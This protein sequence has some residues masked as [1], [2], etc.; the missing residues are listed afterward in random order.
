MG[1]KNRP[2]SAEYSSSMKKIFVFL[3]LFSVFLLHPIFLIG[4]VE[5]SGLDLSP[6]N[7]LLFKATVDV[8]G[9][10]SYDTLFLSTLDNKKII[11]LTYFP[12]K[13]YFLVI[14]KKLQIQN[15]F[16]VFRTDENLKN[17]TPISLFPAFVNGQEVKT[18]KISPIEAS[19]DGR[20]LTY[21][22]AKS[23]AFGQLILY[24]IQTGKETVI[25]E[26]FELDLDGPITLWSPDSKYLVYSSRGN[27]Y[28]YSIDQYLENRVLAED[29]RKFNKGNLSGCRWNK[30][31]NLFYIAGSVVFSFS[32]TD[33]FPQSLYSEFLRM[34][35]ITGSIPFDFDSNFDS[36][37]ISPDGEKI[38]LNKGGA[39]IFLHFFN[40]EDFDSPGNIQSLP[41]LYLPRNTSVKKVLW[42]FGD[43]VTILTT[44]IEK[45]DFKNT[46]FRL[47]IPLEGDVPAFERKSIE[48]VQDIAISPDETKLALL[49]E[50]RVLIYNYF[51][52][53]K[54]TEFSYNQPIKALWRSNTELLVTGIYTYHL[55]NIT[56]NTSK[57]IALSQPGDYGFSKEDK[58]ILT[59]IGSEV[60]KTSPDSVSWQKAYTFETTEKSVASN[61]YRVYLEVTTR[62]SYQNMVMVRDIRGYGTE[63]LFLPEEFEYESFPEVDEPVDFS[64]FSHGSRLR[65]REIALVFNAVDSIEGLTTILNVLSEYNLRCTF[66]INGEV[67]RRYPLATMEIAESGHEVGS[68]FYIPFNMTDAMY[69]LDKEYIKNGLGRTEDEYYNATGKEVSLLWHAPYY[70]INS[71]MIEA[72]REMN[73]IY[74]GRDVDS[75]DWVTKDTLILTSGIYLS[76]SD[77]VERIINLKK[78]G[79]IIPIQIGI[80]EEKREDYLFQKLDVLINGLLKRGYRIVTV[81]ELIENAK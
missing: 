19:P 29:Y 12:E 26:N 50:D 61:Y 73:Y 37:W 58:T 23:V 51:N 39:N 40:S 32:T 59:Q 77:L 44:S 69:D 14:N 1:V 25:S 63:N 80:P 75:M 62:G 78:P 43:I 10:G 52:F 20:F 57:L 21:S 13:I 60:Y 79:S 49:L 65:A 74:V 53:T 8:P 15:R 47:D 81:S 42:S 67:I 35:K 3:S 18:G 70:F 24:D 28:Y 9:W 6:E 68:L 31:N 30:V 56:S 2:Y 48:G 34:G 33:F 64:N 38:L 27:V 22:R 17:I 36:F 46:V 71:D 55:Y 41:Y 76:A 16:G 7:K 45:G 5:F 66:F 72:S 11:Q 4:E 54:I